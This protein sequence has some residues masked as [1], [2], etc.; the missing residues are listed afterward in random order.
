MVPMFGKLRS[1]KKYYEKTTKNFSIII[2]PKN[3]V[4]PANSKYFKSF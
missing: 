1:N 4:P 2:F 3:P